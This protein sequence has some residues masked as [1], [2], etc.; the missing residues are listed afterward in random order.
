MTKRS[1]FEWDST[2]D[3]IN[4]EKHG[5]SFALAQ[6]AFLDHNRIILEDLEHSGNENRYYCLGK[7]TDGIL[8]VRFTYRK[9]KIRI[10]GAGYWRKG[11][12]IYERENKI[13]G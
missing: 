4:Q 7:V 6:L 11:K 2:K 8:T 3:L 13:H 12:K 5:V 9:S 1:D 10:I